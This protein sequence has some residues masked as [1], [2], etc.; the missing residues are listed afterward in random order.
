MNIVLWIV[1]GALAIKLAS[2]AFTHGVRPRTKLRRLEGWLGAAA[3]P[4]L[5]GIG[6]CLFLGALALVLPGAL[7]A[8][9][10][11]TPWAATLLAVLLL[12]ACVFHM[13][14]AEQAKLWADLILCALA[15]LVAV[16]R[17]TIAPL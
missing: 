2:E 17:W 10:W 15:I 4:L 11:L 13:R 1:Q 3:R 5:T 16:G 6:A 12:A 8:A 14:C 9:T 7:G